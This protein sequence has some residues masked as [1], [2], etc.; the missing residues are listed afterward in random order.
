M[1]SGKS[2]VARALCQDR[3]TE[4]I[5]ADLICRGLL[6]PGEKGWLIIKQELGEIFFDSQGR[7]DRQFLRQKIFS[8]ESFRGKLNSLMHPLAWEE[9]R[10]TVARAAEKKQ[11]SR[12]L[13]EV[14]L[15]YEAGWDSFFRKVIVVY[16]D[17][18]TCM[19]RLMERDQLTRKEAGDALATQWPAAR[20]ALLADHVI[21]NS[22]TWWETCLQLKHLRRILWTD[23]TKRNLKKN[24]TATA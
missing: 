7:I 8:E 3:E 13:V 11:K 21:D 20:K 6:E 9:I 5:D 10:N 12:I 16:A 2:S 17:H 19:T 14:P 4:C 15:L 24:L 22:G 1:G 18:D 23:E